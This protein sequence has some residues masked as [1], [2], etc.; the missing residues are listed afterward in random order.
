MVPEMR[1]F[2]EE[3]NE[4]SEEKDYDNV[5]LASFISARSRKKKEELESVLRKNKKETKK[6]RLVKDGK[7]VN[8][9]VVPSTLVVDVDD[10]VDEESYSL[11]RKSSKKLTVSKSKRESSMSE[12]D[13]SKVES[14]KSGEEVIEKS[15][16]RVV[17]ESDEG[18]AE[19]SAEKVS[20]KVANKGKNVR[21]SVKKESWC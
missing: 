19:E 12:K 14:E 20:K 21:K 16:E 18:V 9:K 7:V 10:E 5:A 8:D 2:S 6:R 13:L 1:S 17:E 4:D 11:V 3:E 15:G